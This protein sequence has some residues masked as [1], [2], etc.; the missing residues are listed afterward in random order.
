MEISASYDRVI[1]VRK[2]LALAEAKH[3]AKDEAQR[4]AE[5]GVVVPSNINQA[6]F[7]TGAVDYID[8]SGHIELYRTA[9]FLTN[10]QHGN[11]PSTTHP[12]CY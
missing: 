6:V 1:D 9:I 10:H 11:L 12:Y 7:T 8:E 5:D 4:F 3:S 2:V